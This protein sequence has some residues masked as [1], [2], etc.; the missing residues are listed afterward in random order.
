MIFVFMGL[1]FKR[2][3]PRHLL[4]SILYRFSK[5]PIIPKKIKLKLYLDLTWIYD[6]LSHSL[7]MEYYNSENNPARISTIKFLSKNLSKEQNVLDRY[8]KNP[9]VRLAPCTPPVSITSNSKSS[10]FSK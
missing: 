8:V 9:S 7:A 4:L 3:K 6:R 10:F 2:E 1:R 5:L